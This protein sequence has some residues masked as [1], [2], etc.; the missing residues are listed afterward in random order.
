MYAEPPGAVPAV[1]GAFN[2]SSVLIVYST[3]M[4]VT[5]RRLV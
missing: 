3:N 1:A 4:A 2:L 5:R